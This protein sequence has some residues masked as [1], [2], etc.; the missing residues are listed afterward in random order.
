MATKASLASKMAAEFIGTFA[1]VFAGCGAVMVAERFPGSVAGGAIPVVFGLTVAAMIYAVGHISGAH[2]NPA[3][4]AAFAVARHFPVRQIPAYW[5]AQ[6]VGAFAA[7]GLLYA[8]LPPGST[9]GAAVPHV[10]VPQAVGWEVVLT[11][12]LMFVIIAVATDTRAVG[13]MAGAAIGSTVTLAAYVGGPVT[14]A[15]MNP[16][17]ALAPAFAEGQLTSLWIYF[18]GPLVGAVAAAKLYEWIRCHSQEAED[19]PSK[20]GAAG[21]CC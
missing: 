2:F 8:L 17:R 3:V 11:F 10:S 15:A 20:S 18:V 7:T 5:A 6:F 21:G 16:A 19:T 14:G 1:I 13:T 4:T 12:F 9:F